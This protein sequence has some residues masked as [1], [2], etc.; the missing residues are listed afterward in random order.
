MRSKKTRHKDSRG[1]MIPQAL[2]HLKSEKY[3]SIAT[4]DWRGN[5]HIST[6]I[7]FEVEPSFLYL[8]DQA[9]G[10]T[11]NNIK[12]NRRVALSI[13]NKEEQLCYRIYGLAKLLVKGREYNNLIKTFDV[14][15]VQYA[16]LRVVEGVRRGRKHKKFDLVQAS[17]TVIIKV[18]MKKVIKM[19]LLGSKEEKN[20]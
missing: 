6:K 14:R 20:L 8:V 7:V 9:V 11:S 15:K 5:P 4:S 19:N 18:K 16:A 13:I 10:R 1:K 3:I 2:V 12:R 17:A